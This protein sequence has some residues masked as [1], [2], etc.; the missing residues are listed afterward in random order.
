MTYLLDGLL[1]LALGLLLCRLLRDGAI[2]PGDEPQAAAALIL[3]Q[4]GKDA[5]V[6]LQIQTIRSEDQ[7]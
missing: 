5:V 4:D 3:A 2:T 1:M 7:Q 6:A